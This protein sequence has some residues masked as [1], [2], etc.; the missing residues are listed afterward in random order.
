MARTTARDLCEAALKDLGAKTAG[1]EI[2]SEEAE[3]CLEALN[4]LIDQWG[5]EKF[6][7]PSV[8]RTT[9]TLTASTTSFTVGASGNINI[10][11]PVYIDHINFVDQTPSPDIEYPLRKLTEDE[12]AA[13]PMKAQTSTFPQAYYY[14]PTFS[15]SQ[16]T[17][18]PIPIPTNANLLWALYHWTALTEFASLDTTFT[19]QPA[20]ER[21][22]VKNLALEIAPQ[23]EKEPS[24]LLIRQAMDSM[25]VVKRSN[26]RLSDLQFE[27]GALIGNAGLY[28]I[29]TDRSW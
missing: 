15:S 24:G 7:I 17:L 3:D 14:N 1:T 29:H 4:A 9:A 21:M 13:I 5:A 19:L 16:G 26:V 12:Y 10:V 22:I 2:T 25:S 6:T 18:Y 23:W 8:T 27:A 11:R 20:Y 28:D